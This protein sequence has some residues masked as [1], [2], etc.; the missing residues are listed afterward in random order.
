[1]SMPGWLKAVLVIIAVV[2]IFVLWYFG[3]LTIIWT[4]ISSFCA[5]LISSIV[6]WFNGLDLYGQ[7]LTLGTAGYMVAPDAMDSLVSNVGDAMGDTAG[8]LLDLLGSVASGVVS[9]IFSNPLLLAATAVGIWYFFIRDDEE[10][11]PAIGYSQPKLE[12]GMS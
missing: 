2:L 8:G 7:L 9:S 1:M 5:P 4:A 11:D 10:K 3:L 12:G 6:T